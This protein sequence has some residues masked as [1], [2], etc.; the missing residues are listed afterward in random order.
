MSFNLCVYYDLK[1]QE[2]VYNQ[3]K[4]LKV[5]VSKSCPTLCDPM[6]CSLPSSPV[7]GILQAKILESVAISFSRGSFRLR[8]RTWVSCIAGGLFTNWAAREAQVH[9]YN[10]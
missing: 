1:Y 5:L 10:L 9:A 4:V 7:H 2:I 6:D 8:D 3:M